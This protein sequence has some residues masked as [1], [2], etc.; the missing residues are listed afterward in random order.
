MTS[1]LSPGATMP[2]DVQSADVQLE[3]TKQLN[4]VPKNA[5]YS[6]KLKIKQQA[7]SAKAPA[8]GS[9]AASGLAQSAESAG[10]TAEYETARDTL[11]K[12][13]TKR[14]ELRTQLAALQK[15]QDS[16]D[17]SKNKSRS[18]GP[19]DGSKGGSAG[20]TFFHLIMVALLSL[21]IGAFVSRTSGLPE[22]PVV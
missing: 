20:F 6:Y 12:M 10:L 1:V 5:I 9:I 19:V 18:M 17:F 21:L 8:A 7:E 15:L 16:K 22:Q 4:S 14:T 2:T 3:L 11:Q 13:Q